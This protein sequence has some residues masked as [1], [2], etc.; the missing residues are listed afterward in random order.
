MSFKNPKIQQFF[1]MECY[2]PTFISTFHSETPIA[3][4]PVPEMNDQEKTDIVK[5]WGVWCFSRIELDQLSESLILEQDECSIHFAIRT[6]GSILSSKWFTNHNIRLDGRKSKS[7]TPHRYFDVLLNIAD[8]P[9]SF[10]QYSRCLAILTIAK[11][12]RSESI[13]N[14]VNC[15]RTILKLGNSFADRKADDKSPLKTAYLTALSRMAE[16]QQ[17]QNVLSRSINRMLA[18]FERKSEQFNNLFVMP[19]CILNSRMN[20]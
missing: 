20:L 5:Q 6:L 18:D 10:S 13:L 16:D 14:D 4:F 19:A 3:S 7:L 1:Y 17:L 2:S 15:Q 11:M 9:V 8:L 12:S